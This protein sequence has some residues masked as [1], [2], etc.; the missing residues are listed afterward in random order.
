MRLATSIARDAAIHPPI[1]TLLMSRGEVEVSD[2]WPRQITNASQSWATRKG[3]A[4]IRAALINLAIADD[5]GSVRLLLLGAYQSIPQANTSLRAFGTSVLKSI[6]PEVIETKSRFRRRRLSRR[7]AR[8]LR[9]I[10]MGMTNKQMAQALGIA[11]ETIKSHAANILAKLN[12][13]KRAQ[14]V[15]RAKAIGW[16]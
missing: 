1:S 4:R 9:L 8:V 14:A 6:Q 12:C 2:Q 16:G 15:A 5:S 11:P 3:L 10:S 13:R 7:E